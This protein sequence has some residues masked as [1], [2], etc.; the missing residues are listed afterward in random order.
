MIVSDG[1][2]ILLHVLGFCL[3]YSIGQNGLK[4]KNIFGKKNVFF[5]AALLSGVN[6]LVFE[7]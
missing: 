6:D 7:Y 3:N 4:C 5:S 2:E 1:I